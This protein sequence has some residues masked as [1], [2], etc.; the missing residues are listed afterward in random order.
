[1][2]TQSAK[3]IKH[4]EDLY[5]IPSLAD[6]K[7]DDWSRTRLDRLM[8]DYLLRAGY[9][10]AAAA[11]AS[12][13]QITDLV[14]LDT[15]IS[16]HKI[17]SN[18]SRG[19][20]KDALTWCNQNRLALQKLPPD[21]LKGN[22]EF[23]LRL[24]QYIE[25]VR[26]GSTTKK[27]E[28]MQYAQKFLSP[29]QY[30]NEMMH[31]AG[32]LASG[33][34]P[35]Y[36]NPITN[37]TA[38]NG[39][40]TPKESP[41]TPYFSPTRWSYLSNL[42]IETHHTLLSLPTRPLLHVALTAGLSALKT[43]SCH[44]AFN[45]TSATTPAHP[46]VAMPDATSPVTNGATPALPN[47]T[48]TATS[49]P[50]PINPPPSNI[51]TDHPYHQHQQASTT[52]VPATNTNTTQLNPSLCPICSTELNDLARSVPYAHHTKSYVEPDPVV[53]PNGRIYGRARLEA[54]ARK[55][56][57]SGQL[58]EGEVKDPVVGGVW[59]WGQVGKVYIS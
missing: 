24:Q 58:R 5:D 7:Y 38:I 2:Q 1:M 9:S 6:V 15:F 14:D 39:N 12:E 28:A 56:I 45:P 50:Q 31:P 42:F 34:Q 47:P 10:S 30:P 13:K 37:G 48:T 3:R 33:P 4:L 55:L 35:P 51:P 32:L 26:V 40:H 18:L 53:L 20:P 17:A 16:C 23:Q 43:P 22:L 25:L 11:L 27:I 52:P 44:S 49:T 21:S 19:D 54:Y 57:N 41:Y 59:G 29:T 8:V 36:I 46:K